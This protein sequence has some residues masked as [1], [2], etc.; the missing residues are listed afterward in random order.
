MKKTLSNFAFLGISLAF[1][2]AYV[3]GSANG[4]TQTKEIHQEGGG[5][6]NVSVNVGANATSGSQFDFNGLKGELKNIENKVQNKIQNFIGRRAMIVNGTVTAVGTSTITVDDNGTSITVNFD[7]KTHFRRRFWGV[8]S[9]GEIS[10]GDKVDVIGRYTDNTKT[11]INAVLIRDESI[12]LRKGA[13]FGTVQS[14]TSGGFAMTTIHKDNETVTIGSA[15]I[16]DREENSL[17]VSQ[18]KVGDKVRVRGTWDAKNSTI[19]NVI[20]IKDFSI[21]AIHTFFGSSNPFSASPSPTPVVTPIP[22]PAATP[23]ASPTLTATP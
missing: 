4:V 22:T 7:S 15:K 18:I 1:V 3:S 21:P 12:E 20:E 13:F 9:L 11:A 19:T 2:N 8:S 14:L 17:T 10:V 5:N 6:V 23:E 16:I